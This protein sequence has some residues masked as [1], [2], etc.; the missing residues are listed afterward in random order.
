M[1]MTEGA[2]SKWVNGVREPH[3]AALARIAVVLRVPLEWLVG[4]PNAETPVP[5]PD[6]LAVRRL[7]EKLREA[8][9]AAAVVAASMPDEPDEG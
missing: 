5:I 3:L 9:E 2:V 8:G 1:H 6:Q 4:V 7:I